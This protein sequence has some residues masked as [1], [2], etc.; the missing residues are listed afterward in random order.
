MAQ[1]NSNR[2]FV[3]LRSEQTWGD[4]GIEVAAAT[5]KTFAATGAMAGL[6][7][8]VGLRKIRILVTD[9]NA[10]ISAFQIDV[11]GTDEDG[12]AVTEQFVFEGG[13]S[14]SGTKVYAALTSITLTSHTGGTA[15]DT[16]DAYLAPHNELVPVLD[17]EYG[18][19]LE[20]PV[21]EQP[22]VV[23]DQD[24][25][26]AVQDRR[27]LSGPLKTGVW[28]HQVRRILD[29]ALA[30]SSGETNSAT[31][32]DAIPSI[33]TR[34]HAG[35]KVDSL[36]IEG[37]SEQDVTLSLDLKGRHEETEAVLT[38]PGSYTVPEIPSLTFKNCRFVISLNAGE[39]DD[40]NNR[41]SPVGLSSFSLSY[42]NA[43]K[44]GPPVEDRIDTEKDGRP[45]YLTAG[46][47]MLEI[48]YTA[49]FDRQAYMTLKR[50]KLLSQFKLVAAH[51]NYSTYGEVAT[52]AS[53]GSAVTVTLLADPSAW[54][55][56]GDYVLF[57][58]YMGLSLPCVGRVTAINAGGPD[59]TIATLDEAVKDGDHVFNAAFELRTGPIR[60][61]TMP[62]QRNFD[63]TLLVEVRGQIFTGGAA[64]L[65]YKA[66]RMAL[67]A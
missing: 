64:P 63:D 33:E 66:R 25:F 38:Y 3:E 13:L 5:Q 26:Y 2:T 35:M 42:R 58:N 4:E 55:T 19:G 52:N 49:S 40:F 54:L 47:K 21:R 59:I 37:S 18:V 11:V 20:D 17:G 67:P 44:E 43:L 29:L 53:A 56:V 39:G 24:T 27:N 9:A 7:Q 60:V 34:V 61:S 14:Q 30:R 16:L 65:T 10:S 12:N 50:Q 62:I 41:I 8:P 32:K 57:D 23:G 48:R 36:T 6:V 22:H 45:E 28:P 51:P 31:I 15:A 46:R 1:I